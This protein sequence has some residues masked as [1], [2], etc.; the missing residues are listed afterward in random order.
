MTQRKALALMFDLR[1]ENGRTGT[2]IAWLDESGNGKHLKHTHP[3]RSLKDAKAGDRVVFKDRYILTVLRVKPW[4]TTECKDE[5]EYD[6][7]RSAADWE[8]N[9]DRSV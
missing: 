5:T 2:L 1:A 7:I 3:S 4:R 9:H 8:L 6:W